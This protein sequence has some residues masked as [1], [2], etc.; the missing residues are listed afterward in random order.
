VATGGPRASR[1]GDA[2][3][4]GSVQTSGAGEVKLGAKDEVKLGGRVQDEAPQVDTEDVDRAALAR[5]VKARL[6]S[7]QGCYER[8]LKRSPTLKGKVLVRFSILASGRTGEVEIEESTLGSEAVGSCIRTVIR[9]WVF[10]F[11]P[12]GDVS[13]AYPFVF[14]PASG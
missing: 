3:G 5:Y 8:E 1:A 4:I 14:S 10:P 12:E 7:I 11:K 6:K 13:V 9:G 2:A